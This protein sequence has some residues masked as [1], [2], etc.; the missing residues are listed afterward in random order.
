MRV[1]NMKSFLESNSGL[2]IEEIL[3]GLVD[4]S[5]HLDLNGH[6]IY[7]DV[8]TIFGWALERYNSQVEFFSS[9]ENSKYLEIMFGDKKTV[10]S[11]IVISSFAE[12]ISCKKCGGYL[13]LEMVSNKEF[14]LISKEGDCIEDMNF[15]KTE[16]NV[17]SGELIFTNFFRKDEIYSPGD[18]EINSIKGVI[19]QAEILAKLD[20]GYGQMSNM[21]ADVWKKDDGSEVL[22]TATYRYDKENDWDDEWDFPGYVKMGHIC[23]DVWRWMCAD[24]KVLEKH[25]ERLPENL[26][27]DSSVTMDYKEYTNC[28]VIP[29]KWAIEHY[30]TFNEDPS[31]GIFSKLYKIK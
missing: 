26:V 6:K 8:K 29:G 10:G 11:Q 1:K 12:S 3:K 24:K 23:M 20:I 19:E 21:S 9:K 16:I 5:I 22:I 27:K 30:F 25:S 28:G 31:D 4:G 15:I 2:T 14:K 7:R 17:P 18:C 13:Q